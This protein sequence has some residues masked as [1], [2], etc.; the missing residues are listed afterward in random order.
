MALVVEGE[1]RV[2]GKL[3]SAMGIHKEAI[4]KQF[5]SSHSESPLPSPHPE[6]CVSEKESKKAQGMPP[7]PPLLPYMSVT[8]IN[9]EKKKG[10]TEN[11]S[12]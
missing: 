5:P 12:A 6:T 3:I 7:L 1:M 10:R 8:F 11:R 2:E 9:R 4:P